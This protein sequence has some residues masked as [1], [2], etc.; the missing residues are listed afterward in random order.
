MII[1]KLFDTLYEEA[2]RFITKWRGASFVIAWI[3][4]SGV[5]VNFSEVLF[6]RKSASEAGAG[7]LEGLFDMP[8]YQLVYIAF[9]AFYIGPLIANKTAIF[10]VQR[11]LKRAQGLISSLDASVDN[12][13][14]SAAISAL[15]TARKFAIEAEGQLEFKK[16]LNETYAFSLLVLMLFVVVGRVSVGYVFLFGIPWF[17]IVYFLAQ[18]ML[19]LYLKKI[20]Y[21]KK[22]SDRVASNI[23][24]G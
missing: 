7:L 9:S 15:P 11:E 22:M 3:T 21:F 13:L 5:F 20:Y 19:A 12:M 2:S 18:E 24:E 14:N 23:S 10:A 16:A 1:E 6:W 17:F 8:L 4:V